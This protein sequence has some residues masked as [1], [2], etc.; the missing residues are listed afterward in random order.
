[1]KNVIALNIPQIIAIT[2][3]WQTEIEPVYTRLWQK[4]GVKCGMF[5]KPEL[6]LE[7]YNKLLDQLCSGATNEKI[8]PRRVEHVGE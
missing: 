2:W 5:R 8:H 4:Y 3:V 1:M 7:A 6:H